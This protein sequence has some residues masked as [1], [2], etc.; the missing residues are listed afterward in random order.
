MTTVSQPDLSAS[1]TPQ[2]MRLLLGF[3][4][5]QI[6]VTLVRLR[7]DDA[8]A[9]G[10]RSVAELAETT[11]ASIDGLGRL[12]RAAATL[13]LIREPARDC[14]ELTDLGMTLRA[15]RE[16]A[17][18]L[19]GPV[20][21]VHSRLSD[22]VIS[23]RP[24]SRDVLGVPLWEYLSSRPDEQADFDRG[25][26]ASTKAQTGAIVETIDLSRFRRI[27]DVGGGQGTNLSAIL[28]AAP[29]ARGVLFDQPQ[30]VASA[31]ELFAAKGLSERVELVGGS[32]LESVPTGGDLYILRAVVLNWDDEGARLIL[33][34][35]AE[36]APEGATLL[37]VDP[38][39]PE[40]REPSF[41]DLLM[42][43]A[44]GGRQRTVEE[45]QALL[46]DTGWRFDSV[47]ELPQP[48]HVGPLMLIEAHRPA[49]T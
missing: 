28:Q 26:A 23:G 30:V 25:M 39:M 7:I 8:L 22:A 2:L 3:Q 14:F 16:M 44:F 47:H 27:V 15:N 5:T 46:R 45:H 20:Y 17:E 36:A 34:R 13:G 41:L 42:L 21:L 32:F 6:A 37:I 1:L 49:N 29:Q 10:S 33:R 19:S 4:A 35:C 12:L 38:V 40:S 43:V 9:D 48:L 31:G 24:V 18:V 11:G